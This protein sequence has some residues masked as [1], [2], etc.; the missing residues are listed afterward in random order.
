MHIVNYSALKKKAALPYATGWKDYGDN[1]LSVTRRLGNGKHY[2]IAFMRCLW[3][4]TLRKWNHGCV[5]GRGAH[6]V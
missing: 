5:G 3:Q 1:M 6:G 2:V 4:Q